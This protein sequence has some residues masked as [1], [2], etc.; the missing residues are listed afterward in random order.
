MK[1]TYQTPN[2]WYNTNRS[3]LRKYRGEWIAF[4]N[5]GVVAHD[6]DY[7]KLAEAIG[8]ISA[9]YIIDRIFENEFVEPVRLLPIRFSTGITF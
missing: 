7:L 3:Q 9:P 1:Q 2:D 5:E 4:T 8:D 6:K